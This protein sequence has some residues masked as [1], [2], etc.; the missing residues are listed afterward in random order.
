[1]KTML[2]LSTY[3]VQATSPSIRSSQSCP[4][5]TDNVPITQSRTTKLPSGSQPSPPASEPSPATA[6]QSPTASPSVDK[7]PSP[8]PPQQ[9]TY[10][11]PS[12]PPRACD[13]IRSK[14][15]SNKRRNK[16]T[17]DAVQGS[18]KKESSCHEIKSS[19]SSTTSSSST[20]LIT[21]TITSHRT[22][23]YHLSF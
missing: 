5:N 10:K 6:G 15:A 17:E 19:L 16:R 11:S 22:P 9:G 4:D 18:C 13:V 1:M 21:V 14:S 8:P 12:A 3:L 2:F 20:S 23:I 7:P